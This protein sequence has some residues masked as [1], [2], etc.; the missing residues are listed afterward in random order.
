MI[1][2]KKKKLFFFLAF[3]L[4]SSMVEQDTSNI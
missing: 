1:K 3:T 2:K 4:I